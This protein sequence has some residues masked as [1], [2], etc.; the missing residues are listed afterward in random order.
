MTRRVVFTGLGAMSPN[1]TGKNQFWE[2][3]CN[4]VS[5]I[6]RISSFDPAGLECQIAGQVQ[7]FDPGEYF[8]KADL[9]KLPRTVPLGVAAA[10]EAFSDAGIDLDEFDEEDFE[11]LGVMIGTGG[12]GFDFSEEQFGYYFSQ[13]IHKIS[14]YAISNALVG[15]LSSE[16]SMFFGLQGR[17]HVMSNGCTSSTDAM[18]YAFNAIRSGQE[19]WMLTGGIESCVTPAMMTGFQRMRA[20][21]VHFNEDPTRGSRPFNRD[22][23]GFVLAEGSWMLVMEELEHAKKR[24]AP[25]YAEVIGYGTTCDAFHRV[26]IMPDGK[27][28]TRAL[29]LAMK[30]A[31][32]NEDEVQYINFHG[33]ST[34]INDKIETLAVKGALNGHAMKVP[35]SST[36]SMVGHPQGASGALGAVVTAL[37]LRDGVLS[38]TINIENP[39]PD[40]DMDYIANESREQAVQVAIS[41]CISFGSKNSALVLKKF[42]L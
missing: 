1:G 36:K 33:T 35:V 42:A 30:D 3:T 5:G 26:A 28:S 20:N 34:V 21:P 25:I 22:R 29:L 8:S 4:G 18:G 32:I 9:K 11:S 19:A 2:N 6:R 41:N 24:N 37:S 13:E 27:Q 38:P 12:S 17:S 16:I 23:E 39:D 10:K 31:R 14:P 40:C 7:D 15:M